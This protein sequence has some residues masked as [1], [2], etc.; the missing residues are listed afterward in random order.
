MSRTPEG[1]HQGVF[2]S[3]HRRWSATPPGSGRRGDFGL[4]S[5]RRWV[6]CMTL[7]VQIRFTQKLNICKRSAKRSINC[8]VNKKYFF[9]IA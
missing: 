9:G 8:S 4:G 6:M 1:F 7:E 5:G 3:L 2:G